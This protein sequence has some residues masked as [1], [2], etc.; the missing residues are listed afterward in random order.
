MRKAL[1]TARLALSAAAFLAAPHVVA[2]EA[3]T[4]RA[5]VLWNPIAHGYAVDYERM[6]AKNV[7]VGARYAHFKYDWDDDSTYREE[8][9]VKGF[10][11]TGRYYIA[12]EGFKGFYVGA[13]LG[14]YKSDWTWTDPP[15]SGKGSSNLWH[16]GATV[17]Y[18]Y[19]FNRNFYVDGFAIAGTWAGGGK[20]DSGSKETELGAYV[21]IGAGL[22]VTF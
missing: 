3:N 18:K 21:G 7:S 6:V 20:D 19:F 22:G 9:T 8:G 15:G 10:D 1:G 12:G 4:V 16:Y 11:V 14:R 5:S 17:G 13:A 2:Q